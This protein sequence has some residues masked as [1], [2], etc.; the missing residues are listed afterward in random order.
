MNPYYVSPR[1][2]LARQYAHIM[3]DQRP[4]VHIPVDVLTKDDDYLISA[5]V[6]GLAAEDVSVEIVENV[7]T[8]SGEFVSE[9]DED[10]TSLRNERPSGTFS[11]SLRLPALL[12]AA[13]AEAEVKNGILEL[14]V[15]KAEESKA[16]QIKVKAIK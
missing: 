7:I 12:D 11:R 8:I 6:P 5:F 4:D 15:P 14:R 1:R 3:D 9:L 10:A 2:R 13:G 16:K